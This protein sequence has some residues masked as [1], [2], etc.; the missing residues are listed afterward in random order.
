MQGA[1]FRMPSVDGPNNLERGR[2]LCQQG[3]FQEAVPFF[4]TA[5]GLAER[6]FGENAPEVAEYLEDLADTYA[7]LERDSESLMVFDRLY[8]LAE[9]ILGPN[10]PQVVSVLWK[11]SILAERLGNFGDSYEMC[12]QALGRARLCLRPDD[13]LAKAVVERFAYL[14]EILQSYNAPAEQPIPDYQEYPK[15]ETGSEIGS[16]ISSQIGQSSG[17]PLDLMSNEIV[18][19]PY[20]VYE[21]PRKRN[22][23]AAENAGSG[24]NQMTA[25]EQISGYTENSTQQAMPAPMLTNAPTPAV[26]PV[27]T[28]A[29]P[30]PLPVTMP[31]NAPT[32]MPSG[33]IGSIFSGKGE[34]AR[35]PFSQSLNQALGSTSAIDYDALPNSARGLDADYLEA[36]KRAAI[37]GH[38]TESSVF[39]QRDTG[40]LPEEEDYNISDIENLTG[41]RTPK[42]EHGAKKARKFAQEAD[43]RIVIGR[44][45]KEYLIP[46]AAL[47]VLAGIIIYGTLPLLQ[48]HKDKP[49]IGK[50]NIVE[51]KYLTGD[52]E[53]SIELLS[54]DRARLVTAGSAM[55]VPTKKLENN[56]GS[57]FELIAN[58]LTEKQLLLNKV[59][60]GYESEEGT[61]YYNAVER[62]MQVVEKMRQ[63]A[64]FAQSIF[65]QTGS[66]PV[67]ITPQIS[68][69]FSY[70]NP[71][72]N[73]TWNIPIKQVPSRTENYDSLELTLET[74]STVM[75]SELN[76]P[77][78]IA[79]YVSIS[80]EKDNSQKTNA[81]YLR[82]VGRNGELIRQ[83]KPGLFL[84]VKADN[85][86]MGGLQQPTA[87]PEKPKAK[88][89]KRN[90]RKRESKKVSPSKKEISKDNTEVAPSK[91][92][93]APKIEEITPSKPTRLWI[94][95]GASVPLIVL[96]FG[97]AIT[98]GALTVISFAISRME[99]VDIKG[100][101][102]TNHNHIV[103]GISLFFFLATCA[104]LVIQMTV[105]S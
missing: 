68:T 59:D 5:L 21:D 85:T 43:K 57:Y 102:T 67:T 11:M 55:I 74:G 33:E 35:S 76:K 50:G 6:N 88:E 51:A 49:P 78:N 2:T 60:N 36:N 91:A 9:R 94:I 13:D 8:R 10:H 61:I 44:M 96:H 46:I 90:S 98:L 32:P 3:L 103:L 82:G 27:Q 89:S 24:Q 42:V 84:A 29:E 97:L 18:T 80:G 14:N 39:G 47:V 30:Y 28:T 4:E 17:N 100:E 19:N 63:L 69:E 25:Y 37:P 31:S 45:L 81:F 75:D 92:A 71:F 101:R 53:K 105:Y 26:E 34:I 72:D 104:T 48:P 20:S 7:A 87:Q 70:I 99:G 22:A 1:N 23:E 86:I 56:L 77:G 93:Q 15:S 64:R 40:Y 58:S 62:E 38:L 66:Y 54:G 65:W 52:L 73:K 83:S 41:R 12:N 79:A 95:N 16:Q